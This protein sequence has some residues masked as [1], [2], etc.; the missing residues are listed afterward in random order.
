MKKTL[1]F[2]V[3]VC[4]PFVGQAQVITSQFQ[5]LSVNQIIMKVQL[6]AYEQQRKQ[7]L[8][9]DYRDHA[10]E[11]SKKGDTYGFLM[12]SG[13]ALGTGYYNNQ[14]YYDRGVAFESIHNYR[15]AKK[16]Y[17]QAIKK[18]H[19]SAS[20][21]YELCKANEKDWRKSQKKRKGK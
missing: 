4:L 5:P 15:Q 9:R 10:Y 14:L 3:F 19:S 11:C 17:K 21:A 16:E 7:Q 13:A 1:L 18:G 8:F 6:E 2:I 20:Y 12:Y